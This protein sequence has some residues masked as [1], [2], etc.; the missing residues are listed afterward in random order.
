MSQARYDV[1]KVT[2]PV[3]LTVFFL[4]LMRWYL[5]IDLGDD[6]IYMHDGIPMGL[7]GFILN[8][9]W[10]PLY[11]LWF[12]ALLWIVRDPVVCYFTSW[13]LIVTALA[14]VPTL[15]KRRA[16]WLYTLLILPLPYMVASKFVGLFASAFLVAGLS[17]L[18]GKRLSFAETLCADCV[19]MF[20]VTTCRPEYDNGLLLCAVATIVAVLVEQLTAKRRV[21]ADSRVPASKQSAWLLCGT[22]VMLSLMVIYIGRNQIPS[23]R[24]GM[25]FAQH[26]NV[27]SGI[28]GLIP[29]APDTWRSNYAEL[30]F[31]VDTDKNALT[32]TA[33][34]SQFIRANPRL[35]F[36]HILYNFEDSHA[37]LLVAYVLGVVALPWVLKGSEA[38]RPA[39][40]FV[41]FLS[42]PALAGSVVIFPNPH[43]AAVIVPL[44]TLFAL[45]VI[46][47]E[48]WLRPSIPWALAVGFALLL[49]V[50]AVPHNPPNIP[51]SVER[52]NLYRLQCVRPLDAGA[53]KSNGHAFSV[54]EITP[55]FLEPSRTTSFAYNFGDWNTFERWMS[56]T[57]PAWVSV[58]EDRSAFYGTP[59]LAQR[60]GVPHE[61]I[62]GFL[63][64]A[65]YTP[66]PCEAR[67]QLT[68]YTLDHP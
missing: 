10:A 35:F 40:L 4:I 6:S 8:H 42:I 21:S 68:V 20:V 58:D 50:Y 16:A 1:A 7:S 45:Q 65:G 23:H 24:S 53:P 60:F 67:A 61:Q 54:T 49:Y 25:A 63:L 18:L 2:I 15:F 3:V 37:Y 33:T 51:F 28:K 55:I 13:V 14:L 39:S 38:L 41:L 36:T 29:M 5:G 57:K 31:G 59:S 27:R 11:S 17:W 66:H 34:I 48:R 52:Q 9:D 64:H 12:K 44:V 47:P 43:Y 32:G 19:L 56:S 30:R 22:V 62:E 46:D 26:F